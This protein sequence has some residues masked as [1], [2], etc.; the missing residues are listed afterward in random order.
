MTG[1]E[2]APEL[3]D[4]KKTLELAGVDYRP[5][6]RFDARGA[7]VAHELQGAPPLTRLIDQGRAAWAVELHC[8][9]T[10]MTRVETTNEPRQRVEWNAD[11]VDGPVCLVPGVVALDE[12][13]PGKARGEWLVRG[14]E[15]RTRALPDSLLAYERDGGLEEGRMEVRP[16]LGPREAGA[17]AEALHFT[18][19][20]APDV[21]ERIRTDRTL[22]VAALIGACGWF[23]RL[24]E[25]KGK[26][27]DEPAL[28]REVRERLAAWPG[29]PLWD[30]GD[31]Y[32]PARVATALE[33]LVVSSAEGAGR[34]NRG[35]I[36]GTS[37]RY[38]R[39]QRACVFEQNRHGKWEDADPELKAGVRDR[40]EQLAAA[41]HAGADGLGVFLRKQ[42]G[43]GVA[44]RIWAPPLSPVRMEASQLLRPSPEEEAK[45]A[46]PWEMISPR[47]AS[48]PLFWFLCHI[49]W[50]EEGRFGYTG[51]RLAE[52]FLAG[53]RR[54]RTREGRTRNF[55]RRTGGLAPVR[56]R[57]SVFTDCPLARAWWR[58]RL[59]GQVE[60][61]SRGR[62]ARSTA[63]RVLG[64]GPVW[65]ELAQAGLR[66]VAVVN[67]PRA[68]VAVVAWLDRRLP[69][70]GRLGQ[71]DA[72][73]V[74]AAI[75]D[76]GFRRSF[77]HTPLDELTG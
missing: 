26:E 66:R 70:R 4:S 20:L 77:E 11:D 19:S 37:A 28:A 1:P 35:L 74:L 38:D 59:A 10:L 13:L 36:D 67:H 46:A 15:R 25:R 18:V 33:P 72:K 40:Q 69:E 12:R 68:R 30:E 62:I 58:Y 56:G 45:L 3:A 9:K 44:E 48:R 34:L 17:G 60:H 54:S 29:I 47:L 24:F 73:D 22:Q 39:W 65:S 23:P 6:L 75:A 53:D 64:S 76:H 5:A 8:S 55:L 27:G 31:A 61:A 49:A 16:A 57:L 63:L 7:T 50:I 41:V 42:L 51:Q 2:K 52:I 32:D 71:Q 21:Y 14:A 43:L